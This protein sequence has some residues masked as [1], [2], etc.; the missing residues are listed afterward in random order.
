[1]AKKN[2]GDKSLV[3]SKDYFN[4]L[5]LINDVNIKDYYNDDSSM[6]FIVSVLKNKISVMNS[7]SI[8]RRMV[9]GFVLF[10]FYW[11]SNILSNSVKIHNEETIEDYNVMIDDIKKYIKNEIKLKR[12]YGRKA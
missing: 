2:T 10:K 11:D 6:F 4:S 9:K 5:V 7:F 12:L 8:R 1:M 3:M